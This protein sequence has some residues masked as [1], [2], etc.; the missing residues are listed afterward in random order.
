EDRGV[1]RGRIT[2]TVDTLHEAAGRRRVIDLRGRYGRV[3]CL[4][5]SRVI[6]RDHL[7]ARLEELNPGVA[8]E[9]PDAEIAPDADA[10]IEATAHFRVSDCDFCGGVLK[11]DIVYFGENV[12]K[13]RVVAAFA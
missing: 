1:V 6:P 4:S 10:V 3:I 7:S 11:P 5:C 2:H 9:V 8:D 12:P 13:D